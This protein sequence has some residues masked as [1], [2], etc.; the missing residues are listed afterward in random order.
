MW[1]IEEWARKWLENQR[2]EGKKCLEIKTQGSNYYV[3]HSTNRYDR[4]I[5]KGRKVSKYLG[6]LDK[7]KGFIPKGQNKR[8]VASPRNIT[9]YGNSM[10]LHEMMKDIKPLLKEGFPEHWEEICA[11][12]MVGVSGNVPLKRAEDAW[13]KLYNAEEIHPSLNQKN[14]TRMLREVG[15]NRAG[16][17]II[18]KKLADMSNQ[19][20]YDLSSMF[21][22]SMSINQAEKGYNKNKI[23]VPQINLALLCSADTGLPTMIRSLPGS[24]KDIK[25]LYYSINELDIEGKVLIL[26]RGFFSDG[27]IKFLGGKKGKKI[28][29]VLPARR[30]S[31]YYDTRIHLTEYFSY[32][33][34]LIKCGKRK[35]NDFYLYLFEDQDLRLEEQKTLYRKLEERK[36]DKNKFDDGMKKAGKILIVSDMDVEKQEIYLLL[37]KREVV[38]KMFDTYKTVLNADKLYLQSDESVFGHVFIAFLSLYIHCKLEQHLKNAK[39]NHKFTPI[40]LLYKYSKVYHLE[41]RGRG[42]ISEVPKK[43]MDLD[44]ALG[45]LMFP[46]TIRS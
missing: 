12:A 8:A 4:D 20:V 37:K 39:L 25:T 41:I 5:K 3:Y 2:H 34:R 35:Y 31:R 26:D 46:K 32:H 13:E 19:L 44:E 24:V 16:Q 23:Q 40:D 1:N 15:V 43:V 28:S 27:T 17:N 7:E 22:R 42:I 18:F 29:Y 33:S 14:L 30:N 36:I 10:L 38:E 11:L 6:K 9:E 21:S 45:L